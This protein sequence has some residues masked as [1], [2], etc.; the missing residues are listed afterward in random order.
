MICKQD[1]VAVQLA[2]TL[3]LVVAVPQSQAARALPAATAL[4]VRAA[5]VSRRRARPR[6]ARP[7]QA[8]RQPPH[9]LGLLQVL[10]HAQKC[11][12]RILPWGCWIT[13][14]WRASR[15]GATT[16]LTQVA[17]GLRNQGPSNT[18]VDTYKWLGCI[19]SYEL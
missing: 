16:A 10:P 3:P 15:L 12:L 2:V 4:R 5:Q 6:R 18:D 8:L 19:S 17:F 13:A 14:V 9:P 7:V 11:V 1:E